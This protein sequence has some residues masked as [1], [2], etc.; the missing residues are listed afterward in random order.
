MDCREEQF[1]TVGSSYSRHA[2]AV[3]YQQETADAIACLATT[4]ASDRQAIVNLTATNLALTNELTAVNAKL[5]TALLKVTKLTEQISN[6]TGSKGKTTS[7]TGTKT[8]YCHSHGYACPHHSGNYLSPKEGHN[9]H[10]MNDNK[11]GGHTA[12]YK[13]E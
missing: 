2:N 10:A 4:T 5:I 11:L 6:R 13:A 9:Q 1:Q 3:N 8:Y 12:K 7:G